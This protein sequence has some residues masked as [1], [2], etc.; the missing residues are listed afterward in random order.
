IGCS[1]QDRASTPD[2]GEMQN[3]VDIVLQASLKA[4][5]NVD[6]GA[7]GSY[8]PECTDVGGASTGKIMVGAVYSTHNVPREIGLQDLQSLQDT[9]V[10]AG[11]TE[12]SP[13]H[14]GQQYIAVR[15]R[16]NAASIDMSAEFNGAGDF[17]LVVISNCVIPEE[18]IR[19]SLPPQP[20]LKDI[21]ASAAAVPGYAPA[22]RS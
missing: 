6:P 20:S 9:W 10:A 1:A 11:Y 7:A 2:A 21:P 8:N 4:L 5:Q 17:Y 12:R 13:A 19:S 15:Y 22:L 16:D 3:R 18:P 14:W